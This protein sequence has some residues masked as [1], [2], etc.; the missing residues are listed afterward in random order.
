MIHVLIAGATAIF[1]VFCGLWLHFAN[2]FRR[3]LLCGIAIQD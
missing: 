1:I 3:F 2:R